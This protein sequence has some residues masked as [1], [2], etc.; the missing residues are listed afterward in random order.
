[1]TITNVQKKCVTLVTAASSRTRE[2]QRTLA[3]T[4]L[5]PRPL[6]PPSPFTCNTPSASRH[7]QHRVM[8]RLHTSTVGLWLVNVHRHGPHCKSL[9]IVQSLQFILTHWL[10][11]SFQRRRGETEGAVSSTCLQSK[12][13]R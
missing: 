6:L 3:P 9:S 1:M 5:K 8:P 13:F 2:Q 7:T 12:T 4:M 10:D 11:G